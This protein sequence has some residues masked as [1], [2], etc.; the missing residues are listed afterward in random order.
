M[1]DHLSAA[2]RQHMKECDKPTEYL[3]FIHPS[4]FQMQPCQG[5]QGAQQPRVL[6]ESPESLMAIA[7]K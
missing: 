1:E 2:G 7:S 4:I 6:K 5:Q 3:E